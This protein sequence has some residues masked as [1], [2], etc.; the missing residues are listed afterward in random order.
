[1]QTDS[2]SGVA[3]QVLKTIQEAFVEFGRVFRGAR[4]P[5]MKYRVLVYS[6]RESY[7]TYFERV[8]GRSW[9]ETNRAFYTYSDKTLVLLDLRDDEALRTDVRHE[10]FHAFLHSFWV[11]APA[12][13]NEGL[14][15]YYETSGGANA[16]RTKELLL[17]EEVGAMDS[18]DTLR[19]V[20]YKDYAYSTV[21]VGR[22]TVPRYY[23]QG[24]SLVRFMMDDA[25]RRRA[26]TRFLDALQGGATDDEA[27]TTASRGLTVEKLD[28]EWERARAK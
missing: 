10:A 16:D 26:L 8:H 2:G 14:A 19:A 15:T 22:Y 21:Q 7:R 25:D 5:E 27:W 24:W 3:R 20:G 28:A 23:A 12:W 11:D 17:L 6:I 18:I 13:F 9:P 4:D 1:M